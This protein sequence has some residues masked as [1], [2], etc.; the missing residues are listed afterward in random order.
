MSRGPISRYLRE[1]MRA[2]RVTEG[3]GG[4]RAE[5]E[6]LG[7]K[8][9][10]ETPVVALEE[11]EAALEAEVLRRVARGV[12]LPGFGGVEL[13]PEE[14]PADP[15]EILSRIRR[16]LDALE[17]AVAAGSSAEG[18]E[19][20]EV[21]LEAWLRKRGIRVVKV[22]Q[23]ENPELSKLFSRLAWYMG[24]RYSSL[25]R[26][27]QK[28]KR[29]LSNGDRVVHSLQKASQEETANVTQLATLF[30]DNAFLKDYSYQGRIVRATPSRD[31]RFINFVNG[32]WFEIYLALL[33]ERELP[34]PK[35]LL[36]KI[37]IQLPSGDQGEL[38]LLLAYAGQVFWIEAKTSQSQTG[39]SRYAELR[40]VLDLPTE[41]SFLVLLEATPER[42][43]ALE[44][45]YRLRVL[46]PEELIPALAAFRE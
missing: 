37:Q 4:W 39:V 11:L 30:R 32:D 23:E 3:S 26:F 14:G 29:A 28:L 45:R 22:Y 36:R 46:A 25:S 40:K 38:D 20:E 43:R 5:L 35:R 6:P 8:A 27:L 42:R 34:G 41:R 13:A 18:G 21:D 1:A 44:E 9:V 24:Q 10:A 7:L 33:I 12:P 19:R 31:P 15:G 2:A 17:K 16:D